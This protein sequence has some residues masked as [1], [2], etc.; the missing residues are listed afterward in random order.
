MRIL[1]EKKTSSLPKARAFCF[2]HMRCQFS[3]QFVGANEN[4]MHFN[5]QTIQSAKKRNIGH[6]TLRNEIATKYEQFV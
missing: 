5:Q 4:A 1:S 2:M 3:Q 6:K